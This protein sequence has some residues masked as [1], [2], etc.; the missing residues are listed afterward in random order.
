MQGEQPTTFSVVAKGDPATPKGSPLNE[1]ARER[2][3]FAHLM[4]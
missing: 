1:A 4:S 2:H 3:Y